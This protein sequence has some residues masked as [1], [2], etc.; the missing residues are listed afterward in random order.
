MKTIDSKILNC[1]REK[2][3]GNYLFTGSINIL[4]SMLI[5]SLSGFIFWMLAANIYQEEDVGIA[6]ALIS[7][8]T[9]LSI[10][11]RLG[12]HIS[13]IQFFPRGDKSA[14]LS[15][16]VNITTIVSFLLSIIYI[17][18]IRVWSPKLDILCSD[19][20]VIFVI[21]LIINSIIPLLGY[22][23]IAIRK[24]KF[25]T[26]IYT[27]MGLRLI[28]LYPLSS[29]GAFGI[30]NAVGISSIIA[31]IFSI[32]V[33][34]KFRVKLS[35]TID[36]QYLHDSLTS[37]LANY[38]TNIL[39]LIPNQMIPIM[40]LNLL[41]ARETAIFN[42]PFVI[43]SAVLMV[44]NSVS[45]SLL[46]EGSHGKLIKSTIIK[47]VVISYS[48]IIPIAFVISMYGESLLSLIGKPYIEGF[49]LMKILI[50]SSLLTPP[51]FIYLSILRISGK[52]KELVIICMILFTS[53]IVL[54]YVSLN[55]F[56]LIGVGYAWIV[57]YV[58]GLS[59]IIYQ[60]IYK[61]FYK[62]VES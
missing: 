38:L 53:L 9:L 60:I 43:S 7:S 17:V 49:D 8:M 16:Y 55:E 3:Y 10:L 29:G 42:I 62:F 2:V 51:F 25:N 54:S 58:V 41:G 21:V 31:L 20:G 27:I 56:G 1:M 57:S 39:T 40:V 61:N 50:Y 44:P 46:V 33:L 14:I 35:I 36:K 59:V 28:I 47:A 11:S 4:I 15:T 5:S 45:T 26:F 34:Y 52:V 19:F 13:I 37:S 30:F 6:A 12:F 18:S 22:S 32:Y 24:T 23:F 48:L